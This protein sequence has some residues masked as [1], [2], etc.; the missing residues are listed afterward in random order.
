MILIFHALM[1]QCKNI[2]VYLST[3]TELLLLRSTLCLC[4]FYKTVSCL[5]SQ[6]SGVE[7]SIKRKAP[8]A[9]KYTRIFIDLLFP[10]STTAAS[11]RYKTVFHLCL[12]A[13]YKASKLFSFCCRFFASEWLS[14]R[15]LQN[16]TMLLQ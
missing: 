14:C 16:W 12:F 2:T 6:R 9:S 8:S 11:T 5:K 4:K 7:W 15:E 10:S 1:L 3:N 13:T